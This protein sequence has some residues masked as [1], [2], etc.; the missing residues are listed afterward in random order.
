MKWVGPTLFIS[1]AVATLL[2]G[3]GMG[4]WE[5]SGRLEAVA[6]WV[7]AGLAIVGLYLLALARRS[8]RDIGRR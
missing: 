3:Y 7:A 4:P 1:L 6:P 8:P 2:L 5:G